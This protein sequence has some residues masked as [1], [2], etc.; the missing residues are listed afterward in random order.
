MDEFAL[1]DPNDSHRAPQF[2]ATQ[3]SAFLV[4][5]EHRSRRISHYAYVLGREQ[6]DRNQSD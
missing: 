5:R 2:A 4:D 3:L 6:G 1:V